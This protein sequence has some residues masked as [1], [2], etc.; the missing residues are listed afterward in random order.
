M[1]IFIFWPIGLDF[2]RLDLKIF[3]NGYIHQQFHITE[4]KKEPLY[5]HMPGPY[6]SL[7]KHIKAGPRSLLASSQKEMESNEKL[8][9][10]FKNQICS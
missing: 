7:K 5:W 9:I 10:E 3:Q 4:Y 1:K 6:R 8:N 2:F